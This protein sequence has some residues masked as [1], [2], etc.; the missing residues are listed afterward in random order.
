MLTILDVL[1]KS[2]EFLEKKGIESARTNAEILLADILGCKRLDLYLQYQ[3]PLS[4][5]ETDKYRDYIQRRAEFEPLQYIT[6][7][8]E[9]YGMDFFVT[10]DVL[11][12]RPETE[13]LIESV[14]DSFDE[15][16]SLR[17]LDIGTGTGIIPIVLGK[18]YPEFKLFAM[19]VSEEA[20]EVA[21]KNAEKHNLKERI[22]FFKR[23]IFQEL[24]KSGNQKF[25]LIISNPPYVSI[26]EYKTLQ[27]EITEYEPKE[28]VTDKNDGFLF[29]NRIAEVGRTLLEQNG[30]IFFEVGKDQAEGVKK[31]LEVKG[32]K[33]IQSRKDYLEIERVII[34]QI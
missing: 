4:K 34:A 24:K 29:Y 21:K 1:N 27:K 6:G 5:N 2:A 26:S 9:F 17:V 3:K 11:I 13:I 28:A 12:P 8:V 33:N 31:I 7:K 14:I 30:F 18:N 25:D 23:D 20:L 22:N 10:K 15:K 16:N 32:Y 19:D